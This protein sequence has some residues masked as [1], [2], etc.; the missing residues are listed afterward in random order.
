MNP[1]YGD[2]PVIAWHYSSPA[3]LIDVPA[4]NKDFRKQLVRE[5][6]QAIGSFD[7]Y[8]FKINGR[9]VQMDRE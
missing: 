5:N 2:Q 7:G 9:E 3:T 6:S 8:Q 1:S 4:F